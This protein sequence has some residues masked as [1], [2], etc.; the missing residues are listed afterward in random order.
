VSWSTPAAFALAAGCAALV[1][2]CRRRASQDECRAMAERYVEIALREAPNAKTMTPAQAEAV[3]EVERGL[4]RAVPGYRKVQDRCEEV[5]RAEASC[6]LGAET[7]KAWE[8][9][10]HLSDA[11]G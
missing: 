7:S 1:V 10:V 3:R 8:A 4:K 6:A 11:G 9:C 2:A 5:L